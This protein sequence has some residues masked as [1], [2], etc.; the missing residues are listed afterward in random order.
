VKKKR[1][2]GRHN[3]KRRN[4]MLEILMMLLISMAECSLEV[5]GSAEVYFMAHYQH[6]APSAVPSDYYDVVM[7]HEIPSY[8]C[9]YCSVSS[10][11]ENEIIK[12]VARH[13]RKI[14]PAFTYRSPKYTVADQIV[15][16][17]ADWFPV[18]YH[19]LVKG[20][21]DPEFSVAKTCGD[22]PHPCLCTPWDGLVTDPDACTIEV[23]PRSDVY[24]IGYYLHEDPEI[25]GIRYSYQTK[26]IRYDTTE[27]I[28]IDWTGEPVALEWFIRPDGIG[29][30]QP[31]GICGEI[32][33]V[34]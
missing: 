18:A 25:P 2:I 29:E 19:W 11:D 8:Q 10:L 24:L 17:T 21:D 5:V 15:T 6:E 3:E 34:N 23:P 28:G 32:P 7:W 27:T 9:K 22:V 31:A 13:M 12:H 33:G 20:R 4:K 16:P 14:S 30:F 26:P 1:P